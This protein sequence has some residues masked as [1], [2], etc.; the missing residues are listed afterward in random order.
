MNSSGRFL[1]MHLK[2][3]QAFSLAC[4][5]EYG[6][7]LPIESSG[8]LEERKALF[9]S[10]AWYCMSEEQ[11]EQ[12][13]QHKEVAPYLH[14]LINYAKQ[15]KY[16]IFKQARAYL[17]NNILCTARPHPPIPGQLCMDQ[18]SNFIIYKQIRCVLKY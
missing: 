8:H 16:A 7:L 18:S 15:Y 17:G 1:G 14:S 12:V 13:L 3:G 6:A 5:I 10:A 9:R 11:L 2:I 4:L